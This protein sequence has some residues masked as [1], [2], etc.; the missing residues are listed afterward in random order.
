M[1]ATIIQFI[2][3]PN[4]NRDTDF[5]A[6]PFIAAPHDLVPFAKSGGPIVDH[7]DFACSEMNPQ[8]PA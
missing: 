2:P 8:E 3:R 7:N 4:H 6:I 5:P 1:T